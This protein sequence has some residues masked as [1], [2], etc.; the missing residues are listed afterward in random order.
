M[1]NDPK[2]TD[3]PETVYLFKGTPFRIVMQP[4][5]T[6]PRIKVSPYTKFDKFHRKKRRRN[7]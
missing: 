3:Y 5:T 7:D 2:Y 4:K 1:M 6:E